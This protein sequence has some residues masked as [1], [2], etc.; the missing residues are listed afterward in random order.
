M[1][2]IT[3][4]NQYR[5]VNAHLHSFLQNNEVGAW[6]GFHH[7]HISKLAESLSAALFPRYEVSVE[8]SLQI[9]DVDSDRQRRVWPDILINQGDLTSPLPS[10]A[11]GLT[12][13]T[14]TLPAVQTVMIDEETITYTAVRITDGETRRVVTHFEL[15]SPTNKPPARGA[16]HYRVK[17]EATLRQGIP[18]VEIDY[19]HETTSP[20]GGIP[21]Y[22]RRDPAAFPYVII[23]TDPRPSLEEG[24]ARVY[25]LRVDE[26]LPTI[27]VPL[28][29]Q[30]TFILALDPLYQQTFEGLSSFFGRVDYETLPVA[31]ETYDESDRTRIRL[32]MAAVQQGAGEK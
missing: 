2:L 9:H 11:G 16:A 32:R 20:I 24:T 23:V 22:P 4:Q 10:M 5:G 28:A 8:E 15:L 14:R 13:P 21:S 12:A 7:M 6:V 3:R 30:E 27:A 18:M 17:R 26:P 19:L 31:F 29:G 25:G 1:P